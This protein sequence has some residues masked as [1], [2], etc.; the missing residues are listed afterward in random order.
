MNK[1][2]QPIWILDNEVSKC[3]ICNNIFNLIRR[4]HHCRSCGEVF[5]LL[6]KII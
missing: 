4:K 6:Y 5:I 3:S 1:I 2:D